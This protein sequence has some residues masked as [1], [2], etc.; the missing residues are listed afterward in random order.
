M[1]NERLPQSGDPAALESLEKL[2]HLIRDLVT[3]VAKGF[4]HG[5]YLHGSG[6]TG[7]SYTVL[8][9]LKVLAVPY[10]LHNSRMTAKALFVALKDAPDIIHVLEDVERLTKDADAQGVLRSAMWAQPGDERLVTW[11]TATDGPVRFVFRGGL[12]LISNRPLD[13]LPELKALATRIEVF[14]YEPT[15]AEKTAKMHDLAS[16]GYCQQGKMVIRPDVCLEITKHLLSECS[17]AACRLDLRLQQKSFQTYLQWESELTTLHWQD[18]VAASVREAALHFRHES[19]VTPLETR[20]KQKRNIIR[21]L[22]KQ[23]PDSTK[24]QEQAYMEMANASRADFHRRLAEVRS[25][26][27]DEADAV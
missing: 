12:I 18:L 8:S 16:Q 5:L 20:R 27:F 9:H 24:Q 21:E 26:E 14:R 25:R 23:F 19:N 10:R 15:D 4:K 13:D 3:G 17:A 7:K 2:H 22:M 6:G 1:E 11:N